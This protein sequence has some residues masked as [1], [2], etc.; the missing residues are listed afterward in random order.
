MPTIYSQIIRDR[1]RILICRDGG[2]SL[3]YFRWYSL[4]RKVYELQ[5]GDPDTK[6]GK[7]DMQKMTVD[8]VVNLELSDERWLD[9]FEHVVRQSAKQM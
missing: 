1:I 6:Q 4:A 8:D 5:L 3:N 2:G 7:K 9:L